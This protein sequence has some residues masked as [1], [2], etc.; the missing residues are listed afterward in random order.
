MDW[1]TCTANLLD[2]TTGKVV[3]SAATLGCIPLLIQAFINWALI[4]AGILAIFIV[5]FAGFKYI[6]SGGDPKQADTAR[7]TLMYAVVG[8][9]VVFMSFFIVSAIGQIAG[10]NK[11]CYTLFGFT[12]CH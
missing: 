3:G 9:L 12:N 8:L 2:P 4:A 7:K 5:V 10:L 6:N 11:N 1:S